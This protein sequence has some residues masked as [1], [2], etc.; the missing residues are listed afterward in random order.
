MA[1]ATLGAIPVA[2]TAVVEKVVAV[3]AVVE[4]IWEC[5]LNREGFR[6]ARASGNG[7]KHP[8]H[9]LGDG[10]VFLAPLAELTSQTPVLKLP[11]M[12]RRSADRVARPMRAAPPLHSDVR[13]HL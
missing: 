9:A 5:F 4:R 8:R 10:G 2:A 1:E 6:D 3:E 11:T 13:L 7:H 12:T